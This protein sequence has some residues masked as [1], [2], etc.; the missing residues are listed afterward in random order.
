[1]MHSETGSLRLTHL[2]F[3]QC[4]V[5]ISAFG[6]ELWPIIINLRYMFLIYRFGWK[7]WMEVASFF[8]WN[9]REA[10][11][12]SVMWK[13]QSSGV[14]KISKSWANY[15]CT[16]DSRGLQLGKCAVCICKF[17]FLCVFRM[18]TPALLDLCIIFSFWRTHDFFSYGVQKE[19]HCILLLKGPYSTQIFTSC[20]GLQRSMV[21]S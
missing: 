10:C 12:L 8:S 13:Y 21:K 15:E 14:R 17:T 6:G 9:K 19:A 5:F 3:E 7:D 2:L 18:E 11:E 16:W 4:C 1:M 20:P